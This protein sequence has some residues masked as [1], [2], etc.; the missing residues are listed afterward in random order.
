MN[1]RV[2]RAAEH[3]RELDQLTT[4]CDKA[5]RRICRRLGSPRANDSANFI[6]LIRSDFGRQWR[7]ERCTTACSKAGPGAF[8]ITRPQSAGAMGG[9]PDID[10]VGQHE[11]MPAIK[12]IFRRSPVGQRPLSQRYSRASTLQYSGCRAQKKRMPSI[13]ARSSSGSATRIWSPRCAI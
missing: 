6:G 5:V 1:S 13:Y 9:G 2:R 11:L 3:E 4:F 12:W 8:R 7:P 10:N